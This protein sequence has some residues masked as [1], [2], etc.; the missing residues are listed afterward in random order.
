MR[1]LSDH[2]DDPIRHPFQFRVD[3]I[4]LAGRFEHV[5]MTVERDLVADLRLVVV[6][7]CVGDVRH[8]FSLEILVHIFAQR[9]LFAVSQF[10]VGLGLAFPFALGFQLRLAVLLQQRSLDGD[11]LVAK[12]G[13]S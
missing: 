9:N 8:D 7:P 5:E 4:Q 13:R 6:D 10:G 2:F 1:K 12:V 11:R 3:L